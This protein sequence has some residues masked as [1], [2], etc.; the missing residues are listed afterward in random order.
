MH[1]SVYFKLLDDAAYFATNSLVTDALVLTANFTVNLLRPVSKGLLTAKGQILS[2]GK[3]QF[4]AEAK[5]Y[6]SESVLV[7]HGS[8]TF[9]RSNIASVLNW[10]TYDSPFR[11]G[12]GRQQEY[13][14]LRASVFI[15]TSLDGFIARRDGSFDF[16]HQAAANPMA[17]KNSWPRWT[18]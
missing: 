5:L 15:G 17:T 14:A 10:A 1:G 8:G 3:R 11:K 7:G 4:L 18:R 9:V 12:A 6:D 13:R 2:P 16:L